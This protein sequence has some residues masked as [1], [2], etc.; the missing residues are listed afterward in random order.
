M[1]VDWACRPGGGGRLEIGEEPGGLTHTL[2]DSAYYGNKR[3]VS[4]S[5]P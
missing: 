5:G 2:L 4:R 1:D 3:K